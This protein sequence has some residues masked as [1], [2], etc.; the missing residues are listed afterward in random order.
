MNACWCF[1]WICCLILLMNL[2][3]F[4]YVKFYTDVHFFYF[5]YFLFFLLFDFSFFAIFLQKTIWHF[6]VAWLI[7]LYF[8]HR[9]LKPVAFFVMINMHLT[10]FLI[11]S[12]QIY[13]RTDLLLFLIFNLIWGNFVCTKSK[14]V[15][16]N[17]FGQHS[18]LCQCSWG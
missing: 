6:G 7:S 12:E 1:Y 11:F 14:T 3:Y 13:W 5:F 15:L 17:Y 18:C 4:K 8:N 9:D 16:D 2:M 10:T